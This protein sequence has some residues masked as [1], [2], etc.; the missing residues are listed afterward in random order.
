[1]MINERMQQLAG[2]NLNESSKE[3]KN[4]VL[5]SLGD[6]G[7]HGEKLTVSVKNLEWYANEH[8]TI[9]SA[10]LKSAIKALE[11]EGKVY[12][13]KTKQQISLVESINEASIQA[14][15]GSDAEKLVDGIESA[16]EK[17]FKNSF[18]NVTFTSGLG[19][20]IF[21]AYALGKDRSEWTNSIFENDPMATK[22]LVH[23]F[24]RE[25]MFTGKRYE[26]DPAMGGNL[27][28][29]PAEGSRMAFDRVKVWRKFSSPDIDK[30]I[31][32]WEKHF[33]KLKKAIVDNA[34]NMPPR[35]PLDIRKKL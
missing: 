32:Q 9:S 31:K 17:N 20:Y 10:N 22:I 5:V 35:L 14:P 27:L 29:A 25:G 2:I 28:I 13:D 33:A 7:A 8:W 18:I 6:L 15:Q 30:F 16:F 21:V 11:K 34:D 26:A 24:D 23:D 19:Y 12:F 3:D 1:M 4:T